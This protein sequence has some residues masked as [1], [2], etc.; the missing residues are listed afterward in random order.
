MSH[1]H[2]GGSAQGVLVGA[3]WSYAANV[4]RPA[5]ALKQRGLLETEVHGDEPLGLPRKGLGAYFSTRHEAP[6]LL[7]RATE[8]DHLVDEFDRMAE[9]YA[10]F[11]RPFSGPIFDEALTVIGRWIGPDAR[12]L[13][14]GCGSGTEL[15]RVARLV[16]GGEVVGI[17]LAAGMVNAAH[18]TARAH[19][20]D[21][22]AFFQADVG[23]LPRAFTGKFDLV[24]NC[25]AHHHYPE[26]ATAA[27]EVF[28]CLRPGGV[29]CIVDPGPE[30]YTRMSAPIA[31][32]ADPGWIGF[33]TPE[34][35]RG[36]L[37]DA[38]FG[39][40]AWVGLLP[41]FG[42]AV[43]QKLTGRAVTS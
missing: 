40:T 4:L 29:Y 1:S 24:Y 8:H 6:V 35:F 12:V 13:D 28:R 33:H 26:P 25:L 14:A 38:G 16:P 36:L 21:N 41:G 9:V 39:R 27:A 42:V 34:E 15:E 3:M 19:G 43:G 7:D 37:A 5:Q 20:L 10:A 30:W 2:G 22:T 11:V 31:K 17:D 32:W 23:E 18:R